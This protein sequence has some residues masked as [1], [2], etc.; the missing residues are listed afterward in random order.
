MF[1]SCCTQSIALYDRRIHP[2]PAEFSLQLVDATALLWRLWRLYIL[3]VDTGSRFQAIADAREQK[4]EIERGFYAFNDVHALLAF[5]G[6]GREHAAQQVL[7]D[8]EATARGAQGSNV[9]MA[10]E[11]GLPLGRG[12]PAFAQGQYEAAIEH[13]EPVRDIRP[14]FRRQSRSARPDQPDLDRGGDPRRSDQPCQALPRRA[15]GAQTGQRAGL[16]FASPDG[17]CGFHRL[18]RD[19]PGGLSE[20]FNEAVAYLAKDGGIQV[21]RR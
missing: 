21:P 13:I 3:G 18:R 6:S 7:D 19:P 20:M 4:L 14:P 16:A 12:M 10:H 5:L 11:V 1:H 8:L 9:L 17:A 15:I 2:E